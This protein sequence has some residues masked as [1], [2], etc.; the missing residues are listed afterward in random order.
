MLSLDSM[1]YGTA[2]THTVA[3]LMLLCSPCLYFSFVH[4]CIC[5]SKMLMNLGESL[6]GRKKSGTNSV[7]NPGGIFFPTFLRLMASFAVSGN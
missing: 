4:S 2:T 6:S 5:I 7:Q 3:C 1:I